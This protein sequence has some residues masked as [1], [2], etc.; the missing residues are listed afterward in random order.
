MAETLEQRLIR[1]IRAEGPITV[2]DYMAEALTAPT[3]GYYTERDPLGADG[4]FVTAPEISQMFG[5]LIGLWC[6]EA[7]QRLGQPDPVVL[8]DLGPGRGTLMADALRAA[9][10]VPGFAEAIRVHLVEISPALRARQAETL[11]AYGPTWH[12]EV[13]ELPAQPLL[14]VANEF[15]D[16]LPVRQFEKTPQGWCERLVG[17]DPDAGRLAF[18]LTRPSA[19]AEAYVPERLRDAHAGAV[20]E[21]S[22]AALTIAGELG[23][24][25]AD[26]GGACLIV[27]YG[28]SASACEPTLQALRRHRRA[29]VLSAPGSAD[30]TAH[31][32]FELLGHAARQA[33]AQVHGPAPQSDFLLGLGLDQRTKILRRQARTDQRPAIERARE[34]LVDPDQ[35]GSLFKA[36]ALVPPGY[37]VPAGFPNAGA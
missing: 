16:A 32:D 2:A 6:A 4:D 25:V 26:S 20:F 10:M 37:G 18:A 33:G 21:L 34:R 36:L 22:P 11:A 30:L 13:A 28:R 19:R 35:M 15:F 29:D 27:D 7:W 9:R 1:R 3:G 8:A 31:V 24:R 17:Y 12:A 5:E 14:L 23:R